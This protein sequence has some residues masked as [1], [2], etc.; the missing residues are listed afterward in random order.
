MQRFYLENLNTTIYNIIIDDKNL[1]HQIWR[2]LRSKPGDKM[3]LFDWEDNFDYVFEI[4][5]IKK[6]EIFL[7]QVDRI[8][9]NSEINFELNLFQA[10]PNKVDKI[11]SIIKNWTQIWISNFLFFRADRSQKLVISDKK[12]ERL[13]K[14]IVEAVEQ[15]GRNK[16]PWL[17][18]WEK[19]NFLNLEGQN[20]FL[21]TKNN[22][23]KKLRDVIIDDSEIINLFVWPEGWFS[24]DEVWKFWRNDFISLYLW[25]RILRTEL[26]WISAGFYLIQNK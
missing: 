3:I 14:I 17:V 22:N 6:S 16:I 21:D 12:I 8:K 19:P 10:L 15:C 1:V 5:E 23:S 11:E 18:I 24:E 26:A 20:I 7:E 2:V 4:K 13:K 9:R 25:E